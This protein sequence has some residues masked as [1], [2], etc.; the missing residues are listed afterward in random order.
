MHRI[1]SLACAAALAVTA[2]FTAVPASAVGPVWGY[3]GASGG[4]Y[5]TALGTTISSGL[6]ASSNLTGTTVPASHE[7]Q[8]ASV[9]VPNLVTVGAITSGQVAEPSGDGVKITSTVKTLGINLLNGAIKADALETS[10]FA[11]ASTDGFDGGAATKLVRLVIGGATIPIDVAPNTKIVIPGVASVIVNESKVEKFVNGGTVRALGAALHVT[12][13]KAQGKA[14]AGAEI[15]V[16][17]T[18]A[19]VY[20]AVDTDALAVGGFAY[21]L[22]AG[23]AVGTTTKVLIQPTGAL[24]VPEGG[25][26]GVPYT[27]NVA[28]VKVTNV[29]TVGAVETSMNA[30]TI[31]GFSDVATGAHIAKINLLNGLITADV[32]EVDAHVRKAGEI[33]FSE[34]RTN[35][36]NLTIAGKKIP[37]NIAKNTQIN[38][39]GIARIW[40]NQQVLTSTS[41]T[42]I[43]LRVVLSTAKYGLPIGADIQ[44][45]T[46]SAYIL[47]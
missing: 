20:P 42:V 36:V 5:I 13:L 32:L 11:S 2:A 25:T 6:T 3:H 43:G 38:V 47:G 24:T 22:F 37:I 18:Q 46:A 34:A 1:I 14:P 41:S 40:I 7:T 4:T 16:N 19:L 27:N 8:V 12:L 17:P 35:F 44:V 26:N 31:P 29:A 30:L 28:G 21:G 9:T 10:A 39:L 23:V 33:E 45:A 15:V